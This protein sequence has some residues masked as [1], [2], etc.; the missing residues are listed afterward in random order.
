MLL[1]YLKSTLMNIL[2][3]FKKFILRGNV[4]DLAVGIIVGA[5]FG[6][7]VTSFVNDLLM[8]LVNPLVSIQGGDWKSFQIGPGIKLGNFLSTVIDFLIVGFVI[9][10]VVKAINRIQK[11]KEVAPPPPSKEE[12]LLT[13]I[14]DLLKNK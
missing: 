13:E 9:F 3:E 8:P 6:K 7:I 12:L 4:V 14:R 5:A 11:K 10:L 1:F 2:D